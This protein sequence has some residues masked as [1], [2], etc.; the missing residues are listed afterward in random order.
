MK[1]MLALAVAIT[2]L[3]PALPAAAATPTK[4]AL[5]FIEDDYSKA[6]AQARAQTR[7]RGR[8][9]P[10]F[11]EV[12]APWCH[13]CRSMKAFVFSDASLARDTKRFVWLDIDTEKERNAPFRKQYAVDALPTFFV[14]EPTTEKPVLRWVGSMTLAQLRAFLDAGEA[15]A[16][17]ATSDAETPAAED[18]EAWLRHA[19]RLYA[20]GKNSDAAAAYRTA[21]AVSPAALTTPTVWPAR[22]RAIESALFA[23]D[24]AGEYE[25][26]A[27]LARDSYRQFAGTPSGA[28]I[29]ASGIALAV[30]MPA[31]AAGRA[32]YLQALEA[33]A[34]SAIADEALAIAADD[35]SGVYGAIIDAREDAED[36]LGARE[37]TQKWA[38]FLDQAAAQAP[39][40][41]ARAVYDSH[42]LSA[43]LELDDPGR[44]VAALQASERDLPHDYNPPAR[45]A[46]AYKAMKRWDDA[47]AASDRAL[48]KAYGPRRIGMLQTRADI[49]KGRGDS[50]N[51][52]KTLADA[53]R[54]AEALPPGQRSDNQ[55][56]SLKKKIDAMAMP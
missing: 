40:P 55:I 17:A 37:W 38:A 13:T 25:T 36:S 5:P 31:G 10:L 44:V 15:A 19:D 4:P 56:A 14:I 21:I 43:S 9:Q 49:F 26:G 47:L 51:A 42:R 12:G 6:L 3:P 20:A 1:M 45:L 41:D 22:A 34:R 11:V 52:R 50:D 54:E 35:R 33:A 7:A 53:L 46:T 39:T 2:L 28:N 18:A 32:E 29:A 27:R 16:H 8:L 24:V 23:M 48:A 30:Q